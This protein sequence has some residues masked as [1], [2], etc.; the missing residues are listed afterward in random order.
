MLASLLLAL[1][2]LAPQQSAQTPAADQPWP[3][4]GV[5]RVGAGV[6][7]PKITKEVRP[8]YTKAAMDAG[9]QGGVM[10]EAVV[11]EDG[12]VGEVR[13]KTS[14]DKQFG[15]DEEAVKAVK[16]WRFE[17]GRKDGVAVPVMVEIELKFSVRK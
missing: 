1:S 3:P 17:A 5:Y 15:L 11:R 7:A 14:L 4:A 9:I 10:L 6:S 8:R 16:D 13:V 12:T 2:V